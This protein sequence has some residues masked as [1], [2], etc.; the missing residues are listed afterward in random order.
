MHHHRA[1]ETSPVWWELGSVLNSSLKSHL[2]LLKEAAV[3][4]LWVAALKIIAGWSLDFPHSA[5]TRRIS[6][7]WGLLTSC[8]SDKN[9]E[10]SA[11]QLL[12]GQ[13]ADTCADIHNTY[14]CSNPLSHLNLCLSKPG[15]SC[16]VGKWP[17][18]SSDTFHRWSSWRASQGLP[19]WR[20][21][22][23]TQW[24]VPSLISTTTSSL[25]R[26]WMCGEFIPSTS[27]SSSCC[28]EAVNPAVEQR[29][30]EEPEQVNV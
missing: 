26:N 18:L 29:I 9:N 14:L 21:E 16:V 13:V 1:S 30:W 28:P 24:I 22:T 19:W 6:A 3:M 10:P 4:D 12:T 27:Q 2:F 25:D 11:C 15:H 23:A 8:L 20:W 17:M 7:E 5:D